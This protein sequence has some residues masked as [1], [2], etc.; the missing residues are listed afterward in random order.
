MGQGLGK[1]QKKILETLEGISERYIE[2]DSREQRWVWL[3]VLVIM[4]YHPEQ[5]A[6]EKRNWNWGYS[7]NEHRRI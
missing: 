3:N 5:I 6:G 2:K 4:V 1:I 7:K